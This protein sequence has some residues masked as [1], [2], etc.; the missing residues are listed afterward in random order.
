[1]KTRTYSMLIEVDESVKATEIADAAWKGLK[2]LPGIIGV[3]V[4]PEYGE[5]EIKSITMIK[6]RS[7]QPPPNPNSSPS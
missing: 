6:E 5:G 3:Y 2:A 4:K 1:M 7:C